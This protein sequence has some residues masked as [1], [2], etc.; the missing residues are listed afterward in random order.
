MGCISRNDSVSDLARAII[1]VGRGEIALSPHIAARALAAMARGVT[2]GGGL[3]EPLSERE[4]EVL[5]LLGQGLTNKD[6]A[7]TL[8]VSVRTVEAH[9]RSIFGKLGVRSRTEAA[10]WAI[11]HGYGSNTTPDSNMHMTTSSLRLSKARQV[12]NLPSVA[13]VAPILY[14]T[15][16]ARVGEQRAVIYVIGF[17]PSPGSGEAP[18][19][20]G[21]PWQMVAGTAALRRREAVVD[22]GLATRLGVGLG[23]TVEILGEDFTVAGLSAG[24]TSIANSLAF[25]RR[26]DFA[27]L[28]GLGRTASYLLVDILKA[29]GAR[30]AWLYKVVIEQ[31]FLTI[32][33]GFAIAVALAVVVGRVVGAVLPNVPIV[34]ELGSLVKVLGVAA[35]IGGLTSAIPVRQIAGIDP[36]T[37]F[38][39][40]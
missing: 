4:I 8:I 19:E 11:R 5:R 28:R 22:Q 29:I 9:L 30:N 14:A 37:V 39:G 2:I 10:L 21:G 35:L 25:I 20:G 34:V 38:R 40:G 32:G 27:N 16:V 15:N 7:Q 36:A 6:I 18:G 31:A 3:I 23:D 13:A 1:A 12:A 24:G 26:D 33:L 17:D